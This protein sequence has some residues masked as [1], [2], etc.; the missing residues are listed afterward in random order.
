MGG[1]RI[2][3]NGISANTGGGKSILNNFL[4]V[5]SKS[6]SED[7]YFIVLPRNEQL[8]KYLDSEN[9]RIVKLNFFLKVKIILPFTHRFILPIIINRLQIRRIINLSDLPISTYQFQL[10]L[11]DWAYA[12]Y[13]ES[14]VWKMMEMK[15]YL[16]R[17]IKIFVFERNLRFINVMVAQSDA[18][19]VRLEKKYNIKNVRVINNAVSLENFDAGKKLTFEV[20]TTNK[21]NLLYLTYYYP[22]KNLEIFLEV[23]KLIKDQK[24]DYRL[25]ITLDPIQEG[26]GRDF[27]KRIADDG[28]SDIIINIGKIEMEDVPSVYRQCQGLLMPTL[29]ESFSGTYVEA[30][31]HRIP[32][33]TSDFDFAR[34]ICR[35]GAVYFD[36]FN[37]KEILETI[38][39]VYK[40]LDLKECLIERSYERL[41]DFP[42]WE[43]VSQSFIEIIKNN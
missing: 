30:M 8:T 14:K 4:R 11:F 9:I 28:L 41:K 20:P 24:L 37:S 5:I 33:M 15:E 13:P 19:K 7:R 21:I 32:I 31:Y 39:K 12:L 42:S 1:Q 43:E 29:L 27:L 35:S 38:E 17:K 6:V 16:I 36:P 3:I 25:I 40:N 2:L 10:F 22:H 18:M 34:D 23:G 26:Q